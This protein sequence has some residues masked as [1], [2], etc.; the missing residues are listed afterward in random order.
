MAYAVGLVALVVGSGLGYWMLAPKMSS[1]LVTHTTQ[2]TSLAT[3]SQSTASTLISSTTLTSE[4]GL[5]INV[6]ATQPVS[7]YLGLLQSNQT[8]PY[9]SLARELRKIPDLTNA[10]SL[11]KIT[12][13]ALNATNPEV[14]EAFQLMIKGGTPDRRDFEY[15]IPNYN[16][17]LQVLYWLACQNEFKKDD[18]LA[19]AVA[20]VNGLWVTMGN[21]EVREAVKKDTS[22]LLTFF[23]ET[24]ELQKQKGCYRLEDYPLEAKVALAWTGTTSTL[25]GPFG[26]IRY[27]NY[28]QAT[29]TYRPNI[30]HQPW[31][32]GVFP[33]EGYRWDHMSV[34][35]LKEIQEYAMH[36]S[37]PKDVNK[38]ISTWED[39][40]FGGFM[41]GTTS[42]HWSFITWPDVVANVSGVDV[43]DGGVLNVEYQMQRIFAG[44]NPVG[45]C[46]AE[47]ALV[48]A[49]ARAVG[50]ASVETWRFT[51]DR[52][53][54]ASD[55]AIA[56]YD[57]QTHLW[58]IYS[59][60]IDRNMLGNGDILPSDKLDFWVYKPPVVL[61][62]FLSATADTP[63]YDHSYAGKMFF[64]VRGIKNADFNSM[65]I[66]GVSASQMKQWLLYS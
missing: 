51:L 61:A 19:L 14:K 11:A 1:P 38:Y 30:I 62:G 12:Y 42:D 41:R 33:I 32:T 34:Q 55:T 37:D 58:K 45:D 23:R 63:T 16:T 7:Y 17:E 47:S 35:T 59:E 66:A 5:W 2:Q 40:F 50:V 9:V 64:A 20:M 60:R 52:G 6:S 43:W 56:Y 49:F 3:P 39:Y 25:Q 22:D 44:Q 21:E 28:R 26:L 54:K 65:W 36:K 57:P 27:S 8:E 13:L 10:A 53:Y 4:A 31:P 18:T 48:D 24:N 46:G 29:P 15:V